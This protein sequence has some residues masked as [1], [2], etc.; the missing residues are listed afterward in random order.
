MSVFHSF[1]PMTKF[2]YTI[3]HICFWSRA[4]LRRRRQG[5]RIHPAHQR[6]VHG[7]R[8][9]VQGGSPEGGLPR[10]GGVFA[11]ALHSGRSLSRSRVHYCPRGEL[12]RAS[13]LSKT[14]RASRSRCWHVRESS[15]CQEIRRRC[16]G[17]K[18]TDIGLI[19][20]SF[21]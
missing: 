8:Q 21:T 3:M 5:R 16:N 6:V 15:G 11:V 13:V 9:S 2:T 1:I 12:A 14:P 20:F 4:L 10:H 18:L 7:L 19:R 17:S